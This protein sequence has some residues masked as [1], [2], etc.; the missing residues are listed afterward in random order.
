MNASQAGLGPPLLQLRSSLKLPL[1][2][3][4]HSVVEPVTKGHAAADAL[5]GRAAIATIAISPAKDAQ[6]PIRWEPGVC[7]LSPIPTHLPSLPLTNSVRY[8]AIL[9]SKEAQCPGE[10][11]GADPKS[12]IAKA[13][14][15]HTR[16]KDD[17]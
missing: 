14:A 4:I 2:P 7:L 6:R 9:S 10:Y 1:V 17:F 13:S 11:P 8:A 15:T 5:V 3:A 16:K 12:K